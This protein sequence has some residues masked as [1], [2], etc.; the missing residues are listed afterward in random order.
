MFQNLIQEKKNT[1]V[2][3]KNQQSNTGIQGNEI[4]GQRANETTEP[5]KLDLPYLR[6]YV[7]SLIRQKKNRKLRHKINKHKTK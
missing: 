2:C 5:P 1:T 4:A 3:L 6:N 7:K